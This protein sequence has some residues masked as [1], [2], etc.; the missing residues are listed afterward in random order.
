[1]PLKLHLKYLFLPL[2]IIKL[3]KVR[4]NHY[5]N[6]LIVTSRGHQSA[7]LRPVHTVYGPIMM[8]HLLKDHLYAFGIIMATL[9][10]YTKGRQNA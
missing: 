1:M 4:R 5:L 10:L 9:G 7:S 2:I 8:V 3:I 6:H